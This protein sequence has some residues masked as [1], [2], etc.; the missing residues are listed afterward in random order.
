MSHAIPIQ[1]CELLLHPYVLGYDIEV[2][3][4]IMFASHT[5]WCIL[6]M[7]QD[8]SF[9]CFHVC[10]NTCKM[11]FSPLPIPSKLAISIENRLV[12][13]KNVGHVPR[14]SLVSLDKNTMISWHL[15][16]DCPPKDPCGHQATAVRLGRFLVTD[17]PGPLRDGIGTRDNISL[18]VSF[19]KSHEYPA[20]YQI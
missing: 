6:S 2:S 1:C 17:G 19:I 3:I 9:S 8:T 7:S 12:N 20:R 11:A 14:F 10:L 15:F 16:G 13:P 4:P 5:L 18:H